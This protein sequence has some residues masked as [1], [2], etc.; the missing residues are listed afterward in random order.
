MPQTTF[1]EIGPPGVIHLPPNL[2][3][4]DSMTLRSSLE[5]LENKDASY[6]LKIAPSSTPLSK[7]T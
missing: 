7:L 2:S 5:H 3:M 1:L 6:L 4:V